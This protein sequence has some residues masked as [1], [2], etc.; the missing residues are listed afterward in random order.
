MA[1]QSPLSWKERLIYNRADPR[2]AERNNVRG[3]LNNV[4]L[5]L[6]P[7]TVPV[8]ALRYTYTWG[9]GGL[10]ALLALVL[11]ATGLLLMFRYEARV[12][13]AYL[14]IQQMETQV[15]F[16]SLVRALHHWSANLLVVTAFL[17]LLRVFLS[18]G[19]KEGRAMNW[20][21]GVALLVLVLASNFTGY[22]LPWDQLAYWAITVSTSL[23]AYIP[24]IGQVLSRFLLAGPEVGQGALSNFY[25]FHVVVF[26]SLLAI[27]MGY[28][29]WKIRKNGGI[30]QPREEDGRRVTTLP[31]LLQ[32]EIAAGL[33]LLTTLLMYSML[34]PAPV[35]P[36]A[37]PLESP[38]PAKA[39]WYFL[40]LQELL[41]HMHPLVAIGLVGLALGAL[42]IT[43]ILD[44][45]HADIGIYFRSK[46]GKRSALAGLLLG[47]YLVP[48][49]V[50]LDEYWLDLPGWLSSWPT[51]LSTGLLPFLTTLGFFGLFYL[52]LRKITVQG[53]VI[54]HS[55]A[56]LGVFVFLMTSFIMLTI[57][58][59]LFRGEN[60]ALLL[61]FL[62]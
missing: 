5:H 27:L 35:G 23:F 32:I 39:A 15:M 52:A 38:N 7:T 59:N 8:R 3:I 22:L 36:I 6:H 44:R 57:I 13:Y 9:L 34:R 58:G 11:G 54:N 61:P 26:P 14:S 30:S 56:L 40:G 18:G 50:I 45:N 25:A 19:F 28:H 2:T 4:I 41:L 49:L 16:G 62:H 47:I 12:D 29:F 20:Y 21:I 1:Q 33:V 37:N 48:F 46:Q 53:R 42:F 24:Q 43:P 51:W 17:H 60:M 31:H 55:E 10:S